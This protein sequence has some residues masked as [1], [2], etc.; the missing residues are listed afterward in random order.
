MNSGL[1]VF[2]LCEMYL[3]LSLCNT[4]CA[5]LVNVCTW[6][7]CF[8]RGSKYLC[9]CLCLTHHVCVRG[10]CVYVGEVFPTGKHVSGVFA[11]LPLPGAIGS[12][13]RVCLEC[14]LKSESVA[15]NIMGFLE[16]VHL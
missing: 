8:R 2:A 6:G 13:D 14:F 9:L 12:K 11:S 16:K 1:S 10:E 15:Q 3:S 7:R 5:C 4:T